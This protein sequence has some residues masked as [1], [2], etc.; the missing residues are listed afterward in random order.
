[1]ESPLPGKR[2]LIIV[3]NLAVP[4]DRRVWLEAQALRDARCRVTVIC[5]KM[6]NYTRSYEVLDGI[7]I[8]R[9]PLPFEA[10]HGGFAFLLEYVIALFFQLILSLWI[11]ARSGFDVIHAC[12]PPDTIF[13]VG[14]LYKPFGVRFLFDQ[15]DINPELYVAK[16]G[17]QGFYHRVLLSLEKMTYRT[18]DVVIATNNSYRAIAMERGDK[19]AND[20][21]IV[22]SAPDLRSF[23]P[24]APDERL[25]NGRKYLVAYLGVMGK[26]EGI[27]LLLESVRH[28]VHTENRKDISFLAIGGGPE[29]DRLQQLCRQYKLDSY[30]TFTGR[31]PD[32][33]LLTCLSTADLCVNPDRVNEMNDKSTMNKIME[34]MAVG[35]AI[36]QF[37]MTEGRY[38]AGEASLYAKPN[39]PVDFAKKIAKLL[40]DASLR[41]TMG[42]AG[43]LRLQ[44]QLDWKFS[45]EVLVQAYTHALQ[46]GSSAVEANKAA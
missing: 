8:Y 35:K 43:L 30:V 2:V 15:H 27:D 19:N 45:R 10:A 16:Y 44:K 37:D 46:T 5:P 38:S 42:A 40:A 36:V 28:L 7:K 6:Q 25:K 34:Y 32:S 39:D 17:R 4:F 41:E 1:M 12:N 23:H 22:R 29:R 20:I 13:L 3:E 26:Q 18:A 14:M 24:V 21:F 33:Q 11:F 31:I 9:H